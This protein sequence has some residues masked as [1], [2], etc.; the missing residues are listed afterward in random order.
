MEFKEKLTI[1]QDFEK[2][3]KRNHTFLSFGLI[4]Y[5]DRYDEIKKICWKA[6]QAATKKERN[7]FNEYGTFLMK[8]K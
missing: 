1:K 7:R 2:W 8:G 4:A 6:W 3:W 5:S